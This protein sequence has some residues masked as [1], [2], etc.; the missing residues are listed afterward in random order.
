MTHLWLGDAGQI[1]GVAQQ[2]R[3]YY[4]DTRKNGGADREVFLGYCLVGHV[5][6]TGRIVVVV[7]HDH[8]C[9]DAHYVRLLTGWHFV[10]QRHSKSYRA[11]FLKRVDSKINRGIIKSN[12]LFLSN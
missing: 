7:E 3:I 4:F 11:I 12:L 2:V 6:E 10:F 9:I 8:V 1:Y 5:Q